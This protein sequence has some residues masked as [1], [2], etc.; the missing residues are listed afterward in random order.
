MANSG[1]ANG[2]N[3]TAKQIRQIHDYIDRGESLV[4]IA[5]AFNISKETVLNIKCGTIWKGPH[6]DNQMANCRMILGGK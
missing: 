4:F 6:P 1:R 5:S 2:T 3:L